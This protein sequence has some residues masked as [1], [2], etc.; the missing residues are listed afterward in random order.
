[1]KH[2]LNS[3]KKKIEIQ[4]TR[5]KRLGILVDC[6]NPYLTMDYK[7]EADTSVSIAVLQQLRPKLNIKIE[8]PQQFL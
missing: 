4:K 6:D 3:P 7:V 8:Y 5:F 2:A 1:M